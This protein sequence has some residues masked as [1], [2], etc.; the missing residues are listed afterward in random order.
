MKNR[1]GTLCKSAFWLLLC[2][3]ALP[4]SDQAGLLHAQ[5][6]SAGEAPTSRILF[7]FDASNS[8]SGQWEGELKI[9]LARDILFEM[10]DTLE[11]KE[12]L[13]LA[14]RVYGHQSPVSPQDCSDTRLE[15]PFGR[16]NADKIRETLNRIQPKGTTPIAWSL[17]QAP[18]D[19]PACGTCRNIIVLITD[20]IEACD[21]DP[22]Q[23]SLDLQK[24]GII[25]R[26]FVIGIGSDPG[27]RKTFDCIGEYY[28]TPTREEYRKALKKVISQAL[29][30]TSAQVNLLDS[31]QRPTE[32]DVNMTF[33][34]RY[35]GIIHY[36][37]I[38][39][40][41]AK[42][43][44]DTLSLNPMVTYDIGLQTIPPIRIDSV[45]L[46]AGRHNT[47]SVEAPQGYL[48]I[49]TRRGDAYESE[50]VLVKRAGDQELINMQEMGT[51]EK[52]LVG[53]YDLLIPVFPVMELHD[54]EISQGNTTTVEI[55]APGYV[56][57]NTGQPGVGSLYQMKTSGEQLWVMNL[58]EKTRVQSYLLQP[59]SYRVVFRRDD[60]KS[61]SYSMVKDFKVGEGKPETIKFF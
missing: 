12:D 54:L 56:T 27:F 25:L 29:N 37:M 31:Q 20:G 14:L 35:T 42:G 32:T 30:T 23:V 40:L 38:H 26:P 28:D 17:A 2:L 18:E 33:Y 7:I 4:L 34:E 5:R 49:R 22:C 52:Y 1:T 15:V 39:T 3:W 6:V 16:L 48:Y 53:A 21:G 50:K 41:N 43:N 61:S 60:H 44:P 51:M 55:P 13:Q 24:K 47:I 19:F 57:F 58:Q 59:G 10:L 46:V 11:Q 8:M 36:Y 9:D 45:R